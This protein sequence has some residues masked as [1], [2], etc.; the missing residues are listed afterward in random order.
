MSAPSGSSLD[1]DDAFVFVFDRRSSDPPEIK[2][3]LREL[4]TFLDFKN[5]VKDV[6]AFLFL[7]L[8]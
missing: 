3:A 4:P 7:A 5:R 2:I 8:K 6:S 1:G